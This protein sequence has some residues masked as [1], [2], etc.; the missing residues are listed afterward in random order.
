MSRQVLKFPN[1]P[2]IPKE[3]AV[4]D[5]MNKAQNYA[6][7]YGMNLQNAVQVSPTEITLKTVL[8]WRKRLMLRW[9]TIERYFE[10]LGMAIR[11]VNP[12]DL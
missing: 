4:F 6:K 2:L 1:R 7:A 11:G 12:Y 10:V 9:F 5:A 8:P 3:N